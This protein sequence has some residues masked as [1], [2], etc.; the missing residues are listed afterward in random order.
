MNAN[1]PNTTPINRQEYLIALGKIA[2]NLNTLEHWI[3]T[4]LLLILGKEI[5]SFLWAMLATENFGRILQTLKFAFRYKISDESLIKRFDST[6]TKLDNLNA[7]RNRYLHSL[8]LFAE[9][10]SFVV[11]TKNLKWPSIEHE[12]QPDVSTL[13]Q[14]A[15][16][17][18]IAHKE[19]L[20]FINE[21]FPKPQ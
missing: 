13:N 1:K 17:L 5:A 10:N 3:R 6:Y 9:D 11:R 21:V 8:W 18:S 15:A 7:E 2:V 20:T 4:C 19:L 16:D 12:Y 14:L